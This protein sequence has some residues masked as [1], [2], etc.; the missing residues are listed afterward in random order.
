MT[1][2]TEDLV[3][4]TILAVGAVVLNAPV[5]IAVLFFVGFLLASFALDHLF[6]ALNRWRE[7]PH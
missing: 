1:K 4:A 7:R 5:S 2:R 6:G 3:I